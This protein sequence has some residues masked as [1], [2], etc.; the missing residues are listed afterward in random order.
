MGFFDFL[1]GTESEVVSPQAQVQQVSKFTPEQNDLLK[2]LI[3]QLGSGSN[4]TGVGGFTPIEFQPSSGELSPGLSGVQETSLEALE[5]RALL[6]ATG[7]DANT[8][9]TNKA[10]QSLL[11][12]DATDFNDV[13]TQTVQNPLLET[14]QE[15]ILPGISSQFAGNFFSSDRTGIQERALENLGDTLAQER[16]RLSFQTQES[17][18]DRQLQALGLAPGIQQGQLGELTTLLSAGNVPR[19][20]EQQLTEAERTEFNRQQEQQSLRINQILAALGLD[21]TENIATAPVVLPGSTGFLT[22][23]ASSLAGNASLGG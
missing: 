9:A 5:Q 15:D 11:S 4:A 23:V 14:F 20:V 17:A 12:G 21:A 2:Q 3:E 18:L 6:A 22:S 19:E 10:L 1:L 8:Q 16:S 7:G 13:F